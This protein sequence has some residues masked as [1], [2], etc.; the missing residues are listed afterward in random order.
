MRLIDYLKDKLN[1]NNFM[2]SI[3]TLASGSVIA[4]IIAML[5]SPITTRLFSPEEFGIF[6]VI[7]TAVGMFTPILCGRYDLNIVTEKDEKK[8]Y[9]L[10]KLS[11]II[12]FVM[13]LLVSIG[14]FIYFKFYKDGYDEYLYSI[15][16]LFIL[17]IITGMTNIFTSYNNRMKEYKLMTSVYVIRTVAQNILSVILGVFKTGVLGLLFSNLIGQGLGVK[18]QAKSLMGKREEIKRITNKDMKHV[19]QKYIKQPLISG[20]ASFANSFSYSSINLFIENLFGA[21]TLGFYSMSYRVLGLPL[22]IISNNVSKVFFEEASKEYNEN[23]GF[24]S[25]LR[26]TTKFLIILAIPMVFVLIIASPMVFRIAFGTKWEI[27]GTYVQYLAPMFGVRFVVSAVS[28]AFI[29]VQK[30]DYEILTQ[31]G[32]IISSICI[33]LLV[34]SFGLSTEIYLILITIT[35]SLVYLIYYYLILRCSSGKYR[36]N[37]I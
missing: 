37:N 33:Y 8:V 29:I 31:S 6:T 14:Y 36:K 18:R 27:A 19:A 30:Q 20:P 34:K 5:I 12:T 16:I 24:T 22:G 3:T 13:S 25:S 23:G 10:I 32:F 17:L 9:A 15:F 11:T 21:G 7:T 28:P 1:N 35:F 4:Q 2:K 26:K